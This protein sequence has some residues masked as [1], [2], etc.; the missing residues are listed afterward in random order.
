MV[1]IYP[2]QTFGVLLE[3]RLA[4]P[5]YQRPYKWQPKQVNQLLDDVLNHRSKQCYCLG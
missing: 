3:Q 5:S 1:V 2:V 4:I